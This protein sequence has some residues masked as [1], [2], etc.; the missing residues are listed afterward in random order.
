MDA[1]SAANFGRYRLLYKSITMRK[2]N[3]V[4]DSFNI[5]GLVKN[6]APLIEGDPDIY[7]ETLI[8]DMDTNVTRMKNKLCVD[9]RYT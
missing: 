1:Q 9:K 5:P 2:R 7:V 6:Y 8:A 4:P 3:L